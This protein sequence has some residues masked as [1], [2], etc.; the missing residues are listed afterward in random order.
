MGSDNSLI[1]PGQVHQ[2]RITSVAYGGDGI[3]RLGP[4]VLFVPF[5]APGDTVDLKITEVKKR[6]A[7]AIVDKYISLSD[8]RRE[9]ACP[10]YQSCGGCQYQHVGYTRQTELKQDQVRDL[11][12]RIGRIPQPPVLPIIPCPEE[13]RYRIKAEF[14]WQAP[15]LGYYGADGKTV[16]PIDQC[17][18][19]DEGLQQQFQALK[20]SVSAAPPKT[21]TI[22]LWSSLYPAPGKAQPR[23]ITRKVKDRVFNVPYHGFFQVNSMLTET[24]V[25]TV[26][27]KCG[28]SEENNILDCY[29]GSG[30]FSLFLAAEGAQVT[31]VELD[32][33]A[34]YCA[35]LNG[36]NRS[37]KNVRFVKG[38]A[39]KVLG[40]R[41]FSKYGPF[42]TILLDPPRSG[43]SP[44]ALQKITALNPSR[45]VYISCDPATQARDVIQLSEKGYQLKEIQPIDMFPQ[46]KHIEVVTVL[47][48]K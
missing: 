16:V 33:E 8:S 6:F 9:P 18:L 47:E 22:T 36:K 46:T 19:L 28:V 31:G 45:L 48:K 35:R 12:A 42:N 24:L 1:S 10:H 20:G 27:E 38:Q 39:E 30:L 32:R 29:C 43:C 3:A 23:F 11:F 44:S 25:T 17:C 41:E 40:S 15:H 34:V 7:R 13:Y 21:D 14:H 26:V 5:T 37:F 2:A 4:M